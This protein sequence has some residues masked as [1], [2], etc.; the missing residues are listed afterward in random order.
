MIKQFIKKY[1]N[2]QIKS[3]KEYH[4]D[5]LTWQENY[6]EYGKYHGTNN[7]IIN[8]NQN[9][10]YD[11]YTTMKKQT[12]YR[13]GIQNGEVKLW[14]SNGDISLEAFYLNGQYHGTIK[15][16]N[17]KNL[18][19]TIEYINGKKHGQLITYNINGQITKEEIYQNDILI[20]TKNY[21]SPI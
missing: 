11:I 14:D 5:I 21:N 3:Y 18:Y 8:D 15:L 2:Y 12:D 6:D 7:S 17:Q 20:E 13:H 19:Q 16:Y 10:I 4:N 9:N 1:N